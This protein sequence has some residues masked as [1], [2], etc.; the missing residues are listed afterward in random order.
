MIQFLCG[1]AVFAL[2]PFLASDRPLHIVFSSITFLTH[3]LYFGLFDKSSADL[4]YTEQFSWIAGI[5]AEYHVGIDGLSQALVWLTTL[6]LV[7]AIPASSAIRKAHKGELD[8]DRVRNPLSEEEKLDLYER[9]R[10]ASESL[11]NDGKKR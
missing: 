4:Q 2:T 11:P 6:L 10:S 9:L 7:I 5:G 8:K 1:G 3:L